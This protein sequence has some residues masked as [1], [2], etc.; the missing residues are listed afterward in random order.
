MDENMEF[1][2]SEYDKNRINKF[3]KFLAKKNAESTFFVEFDRYM[4]LA[5]YDPVFGYY[6]SKKAKIGKYGDFI[7]SPEVSPLF[8]KC[9][10]NASINALKDFINPIVMEIGAGTGNFAIDY[11]KALKKL[12]IRIHKYLILEL[13]SD[14]RQVQQKNIKSAFPEDYHFFE[15]ISYLPEQSINGVVFANEVLDAMPVKLSEKNL[16]VLSH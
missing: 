9:V 13:S 4:E 16:L 15:W 3:I 2:L 1:Y 5:L 8:A 10:A 14:L 12:N 6:M 7:T 11:F